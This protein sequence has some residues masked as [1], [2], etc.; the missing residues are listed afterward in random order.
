[1]PYPSGIPIPDMEE[2]PNVLVE[3]QVPPK[4]KTVIVKRVVR[5]TVP[6]KEE[7]Q[8]KEKESVPASSLQDDVPIG[9][10]VFDEVSKKW[11]LV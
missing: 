9:N 3:P 7:K 5:K 8:E 10:I 1:V 6:K 4:K 11:K 2:V